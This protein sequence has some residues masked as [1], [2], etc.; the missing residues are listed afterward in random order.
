M[1]QVL[2]LYGMF[3]LEGIALIGM[4]IFWQEQGIFEKIGK[5]LTVE[6]AEYSSY[7]DFRGVY[8]EESK[9]EKPR[10]EYVNGSINAGIHLLSELIEAYDY[11][12]RK[13]EIKVHSITNPKNEERLDYYDAETTKMNFDLAGIY[14]IKVSTV[15]DGNRVSIGT[16]RIPV[17]K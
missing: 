16:V 14:T 5:R 13:L 7:A 8:Q 3:V 15:D 4:V 12:D 11:A 10:I 17:N 2:K 9:K 6:K 1:K